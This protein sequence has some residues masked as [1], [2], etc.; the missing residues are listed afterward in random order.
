MNKMVVVAVALFSV[1]TVGLAKVTT[2]NSE[3]EFNKIIE[4]DMVV[5]EFVKPNCKG[6]ELVGDALE[7]VSRE[8]PAVTFAEVPQSAGVSIPEAAEPTGK[9]SYPT[10]VFYKAGEEV[11]RKVGGC[12][13]FAPLLKGYVRNFLGVTGNG[14]AKAQ[15]KRMKKMEEESDE[16]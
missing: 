11:G 14:S 9:Q 16:D 6:C 8:F 10:F 3:Q 7:V 15:P 12:E 4:K 5:V 13:D 2:I 1:S